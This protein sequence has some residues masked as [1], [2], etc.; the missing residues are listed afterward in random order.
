MTES[1]LIKRYRHIFGPVLSRRLGLSLGIDLIPHKTCSLNC[2]YC[3]CGSTT[4][5]T[6]EVKEYI[7]A[8][9]IIDEL[10]DFLK[11]L[12]EIDYITLAGSGEPTLN[13]QIKKI[14]DYIKA[15]Y[16]YRIAL[17]TNAT[18]FTDRSIIES[19]KDIDLILP[20]LD[21]ASDDV[22]LRINRP[23]RS[24]KVGDIIDGLINLRKEYNGLI[25]L[26]VF[27]VPGINDSIDE[28]KKISDAARKIRPD[29]IQL[30]SLDRPPAVKGVKKAEYRELIK[31]ASYFEPVAEIISQFEPRQFDINTEEIEKIILEMINRRP[32][33]REEIEILFSSRIY[34]AR[35]AIDRLLDSKL[36]KVIH[37]PRGEYF[38]VE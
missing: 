29:K 14:V 25:F 12:P 37:G 21:A 7:K 23:H 13:S 4:T 9:E 18:L 36:I 2:I 15:N 33:T 16:K 38:G 8:D 26:E 1:N 5:L 20:S 22:F 28:I 35:V 31:I 34:E 24:I 32:C 30:N 17:L 10:S 27:I 11:G 3:E 19:V 6:N